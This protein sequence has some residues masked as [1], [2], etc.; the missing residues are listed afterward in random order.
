MAKPKKKR[1][2]SSGA[3]RASNYRRS[4]KNPKMFGKRRSNHR[5][6]SSNPFQFFGG[7]A[8]PK[9]VG[10]AVIGVMAGVG[11]TR[12]VTNMLPASFTSSNLTHALSA[13]AVALA[14]WW[15][16]SMVDGEFAAAVGLGG[17]A[18]ATNAGLNAVMP[19]AGSYVGI[20]GMRRG[21]GD[22]VPADQSGFMTTLRPSMSIPATGNLGPAAYPSAYGRGS[23]AA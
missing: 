10:K 16:L 13:A 12:M 18:Y 11:A 6:R 20:S 22:F 9:T 3:R 4:R 7:A 14:E 21:T 15:A 19:E 17:L 8:R 5:R 23:I 2:A 1:K